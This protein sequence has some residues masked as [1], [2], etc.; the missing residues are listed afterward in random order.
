MD[1]STAP[2]DDLLTRI[3]AAMDEPAAVE[4]QAPDMDETQSVETD[5]QPPEGAQDEDEQ[6][7]E[8][9]EAT[10]D[11][12]ADVVEETTEGDGLD[13]TTEDFA[14]LLGV[15]GDAISVGEDG[16]V[17]IRTKAGE[18]IQNVSLQALIK[19][20]QTEKH[21][22]Q[23][24]QEVSEARKAFETERG[25]YVQKVTTQLNE[26]ANLTQLF[27]QQLLSEFNGVNWETL[28]A[29]NPAEFAA[30]RQD[31]ADKQA[32]LNNA[33]TQLGAQAQQLNADQQAEMAGQRNEM[34]ATE[35]EALLTAIPAWSDGEVAKTEK[36]AIGA[37]A[38][39]KYG[40]SDADLDQITD[41]RAIL[42]LRDAMRYRQGKGKAEVVKKKIKSLPKITKP[43]SNKQRK[44]PESEQVKARKIRL[45]K[46]GTVRDAAA[47]L[48]DRM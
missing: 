10:A 4:A 17:L 30:R 19:A 15:S 43:G 38:A 32:A 46:T 3:E 35:G 27:E 29:T 31:F 48:M 33:K 47:A 7:V 39:E 13:L 20:H 8:T 25:E 40:F 2:G 16:E 6:T 41:H 1:E 24:S 26:A 12:D 11:T 45:R 42:V 9:D 44:N 37:Y 34:L 5:T 22:T 28:R 18:D 14:E 23:K 21:V 36:A